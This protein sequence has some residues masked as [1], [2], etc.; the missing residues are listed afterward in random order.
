ML[1]QHPIVKNELHSPTIVK[2]NARGRIKEFLK[3]NATHIRIALGNK[4]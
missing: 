1:F 3:Y 4:V 2:Y